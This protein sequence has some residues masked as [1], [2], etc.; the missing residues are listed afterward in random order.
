MYGAMFISLIFLTVVSQQH[1]D[2]LG[3]INVPG[4]VIAL[5]CNNENEEF[6]IEG[7]KSPILVSVE[8]YCIGKWIFERFDESGNL[9]KLKGEDISIKDSFNVVEDMEIEL[10]ISTGENVP[11]LQITS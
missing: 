5:V 4:N 9:W 7:Y 10:P 1:T 2:R 6:T 8:K 11:V 3:F